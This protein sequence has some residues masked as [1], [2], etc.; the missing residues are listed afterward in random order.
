[1]V[2]ALH[3]N[4]LVLNIL[5]QWQSNI[6][7]PPWEHW[8]AAITPHGSQM[9]ATPRHPPRETDGGPPAEM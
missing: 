7:T 9:A 2:V 1:M 3:M 5:G 4:Q 6:T 8:T